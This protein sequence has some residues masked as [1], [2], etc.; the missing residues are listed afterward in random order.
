MPQFKLLKPYDAGGDLS[1]EW[2]VKYQ[3]LKPIHLQ[4]PGE[5]LY[6]RFKVGKTINCYHTVKERRERLNVVLKGM[7]I[8]LDNGF[9]PYEEFNLVDKVQYAGYNI[10]GCIDKY[11]AEVENDLRPN[12]YKKYKERLGIFKLWLEGKGMDNHMIFHITKQQI[13]E[14][15]KSKQI[16][17]VWSNKTYNH[18]LQA[19]STFYQYFIDNYD[20]YV[21]ENP[22]DKLKRLQVIKK[23]NRPFDNHDL[24]VALDWAE[25]NE[26][27]LHKFMKFIYYTCFRPDAELRLLRIWDIDLVS[28]KIAVP[29]DNAKSKIRQYIP[30]DNVLYE[31]LINLKLH[32]YP[33]DSYVFG[34]KGIP[35]PDPVHERYFNKRFKKLKEATNINPETNL[36]SMKHTKAIH[37]V[38]DG[39]DLYNI[40][41]LT[42]HKTLAE[43][44][45]YLK[46]MGVILGDKV[47]LKTR[48]I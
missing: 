15:L 37:M 38:E 22:C 31:M 28:R 41:K 10:C 24:P 26:P 42:R 34:K 5:P 21:N 48:R 44:M 23:G 7:K 4:K 39:E 18:Y 47:E 6:E 9:N 17:E 14:F 16:S 35:G 11:L 3:F 36:Y 1:K 2:F 25:K 8:L 33:R 20:G 13:F 43:L 27:Y 45:D 12:T 46:E 19:I 30:V 32:E 40:I 29:A